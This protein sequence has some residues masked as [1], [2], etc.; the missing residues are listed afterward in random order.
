MTAV[1]HQAGSFILRLV[2]NGPFPFSGNLDCG[3]D[4]GAPR[5]FVVFLGVLPV[6]LAIVERFTACGLDI[7]RLDSQMLIHRQ[8]ILPY[9]DVARHWVAPGGIC[10]RSHSAA[11]AAPRAGVD[12]WSRACSLDCFWDRV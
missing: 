12:R 1:I 10:A 2:R 11:A 8:Q 5:A 7:R 9:Y 3:D 6:M 4:C